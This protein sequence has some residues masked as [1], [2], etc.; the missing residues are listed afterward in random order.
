MRPVL[1]GTGR[2]LSGHADRSYRLLPLVIL[3]AAANLPRNVGAGVSGRD[4]H[5]EAKWHPSAGATEF[6]GIVETD[7]D[8]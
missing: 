3:M 1:C 4:V 6:F 5:E 7:S 2:L 8:S